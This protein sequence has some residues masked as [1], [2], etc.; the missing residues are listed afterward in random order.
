MKESKAMLNRYW[1]EKSITLRLTYVILAVV[2]ISIGSFIGMKSASAASLKS[3][4]VISSD[5]LTLGDIFDNLEHNASY[6]IGPAP[7]PGKD[8]TLNARTL[9][10][11]ASALDMSW[12][13]TST[14]EQITIRREATVVSYDA[15]ETTLRNSLKSEGVNGRFDL[16][17]SNGKPSIVLPFDMNE[18]VEVSSITYNRGKDYFKATLVAPSKE[19]PVKKINVSGMIDRLTSVPVLTVNLKNGDVI[20]E[21]D[22]EMIEIS[23]HDLQHNMI[24]NKDHMIGLTPRRIAYAGKFLPEGSLI[25]PQLVKRGSRVSITF[26]EGPLVLTA[27]GKALQSGAKG[28]IIRITNLNSSRT[29][30]AVVSSSN[31]VIAR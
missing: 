26:T 4:S 29:I 10:R 8:M 20:G 24:T 23:Q 17:L 19:N 18:N 5:K 22:I 13:P 30:D 3:V 2:L 27:K 6:V 21:N 25:K 15:I 9:Y 12:R 7:Q 11:I 16:K 28:D 1:N 14:S 31:Q